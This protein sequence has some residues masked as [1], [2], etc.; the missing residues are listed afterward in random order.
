MREQLHNNFFETENKNTEGT[1]IG[2]DIFLN[3]E[4]KEITVYR[5]GWRIEF[6]Y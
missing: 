4:K 2:R 5:D 1:L 3:E 6:S